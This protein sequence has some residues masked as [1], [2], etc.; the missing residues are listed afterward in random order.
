MTCNKLIARP[1][2][3]ILRVLCGTSDICPHIKKEVKGITLMIAQ[4]NAKCP[5]DGIC[6]YKK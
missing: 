1:K 3:K 4:A 6:K 2:N 5:F